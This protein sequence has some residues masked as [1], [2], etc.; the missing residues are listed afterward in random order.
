MKVFNIISLLFYSCSLFAQHPVTPISANVE[1]YNGKPTIMLNGQPQNPMFY[2]LTDVPGGRWSWE[3]LPKHT[4]KSFC[5]QGFNLIQVDLAF[6]HVWKED[7]TINLD[8]A[9]RQLRGV[10]DICPCAAIMI[11]FHVNP[12]KWWQHKY[13]EENTL[14]ADTTAKPDYN[15][16]L[17]RII[18]DDAGTPERF[19]LASKKWLM[20]AG[21]KMK[22]FL[23]E[24][25]QLPE[26]NA[27]A[28]IQ[29]A[30]G[31]YGEWH[32]WGFI[33]N[34]PDMS[35]PMQVYFKNWLKEKYHNN[36]GLQKAWNNKVVTLDNAAAPSLAQRRTTQ[37]GIFRDPQKERNVIDYYEA[38]HNCVADDIIYFCKLVKDNWRRPVIT[39]AFY[40]YF[41]S[42]FGREAAGG[43]LALQKILQSPYIDFLSAPN[44]YYPESKETGEPYRSRSLIN[45]VTLHG[46]LW[47]DEMD[48]QPP[49]LH[50]K[51]SAYK[52]S[53]AK[54]IANVRR[55]VMFTFSKGVG[56]WFYDF[57]PSG[58]NG[59]TRLND[60]GSWGWWDDPFL[61]QDI[62]HLKKLLDEK[63][64]TP[65]KSDADV[66]LVHDT[67][68]FYNTGSEKNSSYMGHWTNNWI[69]PAIFKS[70][71]VHDVLHI[72]DLDKVNLSQYKAVVFIN[73]WVLNDAQKKFIQ[74]KV[75]AGQRHLIFLYAPGYSNEQVLSKDFIQSVT[76]IQVQQI[77]QQKTTTVVINDSI[78]PGYSYSVWNNAV[79]PFFIVS[80]KN[81]VS[82]GRLKDSAGV[83]FA[84]KDF[85]DH[86]SWFM[87][88]PSAS[89]GLWRYIFQE[90]HANI[91]DR[92]ED[93]FYSGHGILSIHTLKG[94]E[95]NI[96]LKNGKSIQLIL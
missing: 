14:Y 3:E 49:L 57:G 71:V 95:R 77:E 38:Q 44:T 59:G 82:L 43:H 24:L 91:Y 18:E 36:E 27:I 16:G 30:S 37:A 11:R 88:L 89:S 23:Q 86:T 52:T 28:S 93:I 26:A 58:F 17:Q 6:D 53:V 35:E 50:F 92:D 21:E 8:T 76:G 70:G 65:Y 31:V 66:L 15:W 41:Y 51:D 39:G 87:A 40:G 19:S 10:L 62:G 83:A 69:P 74:T 46:K 55:N 78:V 63:I 32:Y 34:E 33:N 22:T 60:H 81:A 25:Q 5:E 56:L 79:N 20:E 4:M 45:S 47:L 84:K 64:N 96:K 42:V 80:D 1:M 13:P 29:V 7:G 2:A 61:M 9:Q 75:A 73:T 48:Q 68:S 72:D 54:S 12:P 67:R 90:A 85:R 94:G